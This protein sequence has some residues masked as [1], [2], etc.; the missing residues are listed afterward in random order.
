[1]FDTILRQF[2]QLFKPNH[3][4]NLERYISAHRPTCAADVER[5]E[6]QYAKYVTGGLV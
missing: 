3:Q 2:T 4:T 1:M 5:L 6:R